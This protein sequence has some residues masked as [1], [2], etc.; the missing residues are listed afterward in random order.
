[1]GLGKLIIEHCD[2]YIA[3]QEAEKGFMLLENEIT[4]I[5]HINNKLDSD[6]G[7]SI[8]WGR[9]AI[10]TRSVSGPLL[11]IKQASRSGLLKGIIFSG[12]SGNKS[13]YGQWKDTHMPP[14][15][16]FN[17]PS[18]A[19]GSLMTIAQIEKSLQ[20]CDC[21]QL[22]FIGGKISLSPNQA[23]VNIRISYIKSLITLLD[24]VII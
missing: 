7:I 1:L 16:A 22:N 9:S 2:A 23:S 19:S 17:I 24:R 5:K 15:Q 20:Q 8:N 4:A 3:G 11:H 12:A 13:P 6:I 18:Y 10:E 14:E 21:H